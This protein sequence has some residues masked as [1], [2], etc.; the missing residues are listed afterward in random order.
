MT[1]WFCIP[2]GLLHRCR[3]SRWGWLD[4]STVR[5]HELCLSDH[6]QHAEM[7]YPKACGWWPGRFVALTFNLWFILS[8]MWQVYWSIPVEKCFFES[9]WSLRHWTCK[10]YFDKDLQTALSLQ[11]NTLVYWHSAE[12][13]G[14]TIGTCDLWSGSRTNVHGWARGTPYS[15]IGIPFYIWCTNDHATTE[16]SCSFIWLQCFNE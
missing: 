7:C 8:P 13:Y 2:D 16:C 15:V 3:C 11:I 9:T 6:L 12:R 4:M 10:R 1:S 14:R 5:E